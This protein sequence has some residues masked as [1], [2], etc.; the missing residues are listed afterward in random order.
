MNIHYDFEIQANFGYNPNMVTMPARDP[1]L[2]RFTTLIWHGY[3]GITP[4]VYKEDPYN[5]EVVRIIFS[6]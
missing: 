6:Y 3:E 1:R 4:V 2:K 5:K